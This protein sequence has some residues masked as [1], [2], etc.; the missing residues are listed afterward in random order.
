[1]ASTRTPHSSCG[2]SSQASCTPL[3]R[4][5]IL[6]ERMIQWFPGH[7]AKAE[8]DLKEQLRAVDIIF[9][10][11]DGRIPMSTRHP[12]V[13]KWA[14][15]KPRLLLLNRRDMIT[16]ADRQAWT[17]FFVSRGRKVMWTD[18]NQGDGVT[19]VRRG[20]ACGLFF[21]VYAAA[22]RSR[23]VFKSYGSRKVLRGPA[24]EGNGGAGGSHT[25]CLHCT[26]A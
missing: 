15:N 8:R 5:L 14:G 16:E 9:E 20:G 10:V 24:S 2:S 4:L 18:G 26:A 22:E 1:M 11:R 23:A 3:P 25:T 6:Q 12:H 21:A 7:I 19:R 13:P 17:E